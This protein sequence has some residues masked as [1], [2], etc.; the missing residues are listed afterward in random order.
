M[1]AQFG[2]EKYRLDPAVLADHGESLWAN[3]GRINVKLAN[4]TLQSYFI[5]VVSKDTGKSMVHAEFE[6]MKAI[7]G[8]TPDFAPNPVGL[9]TY[10]AIPDTHFFL[11]EFRHFGDEMPDPEDFTLRL[12][13]LH[14]N[15]QSP[16]GKFGFHVTTYAGNLPQMVDWESSWEVFFTKGLRH[17]LDFEIKAKGPDPE[18]DRLLPMLFSRVIPRLLRPLEANGRSIKPSLVHGDLW[19]ANTGRDTETDEF[20]QWRPTCNKFDETYSAAYHKH[21]EKSPPV[22]DYDG[23]V[24]LYKFDMAMK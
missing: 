24:D 15:S 4:G 7:H 2:K 8:I 6:S 5:K 14:Q 9:G 19:Y 10:T 13:K 23:R 1:E 3:T 20:G 17:A 16:N 21:V 12:A 11:C 22:E 18:L